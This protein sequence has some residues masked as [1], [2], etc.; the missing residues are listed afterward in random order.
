MVT[1][2]KNCRHLLTG[3][4]KIC[5]HRDFTSR[6]DTFCHF[7]SPDSSQL[8]N[9]GWNP[10]IT[11]NVAHWSSD[12]KWQSSILIIQKCP[13]AALQIIIKYLLILIWLTR[14]ALP[15]EQEVL[16]ESYASSGRDQLNCFG[17][18]CGIMKNLERQ[19]LT[20]TA[21]W[22]S[23]TLS[24]YV[25]STFI[26]THFKSTRLTPNFSWEQSILSH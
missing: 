15:W 1:G 13:A 3:Q 12:P 7:P 23:G 5:V 14:A 24:E 20:Q 10:E 18:G 9:Q 11:F 8:A 25:C 2:V 16:V 19:N 26:G 21:T 22:L 6:L 4:F 17:Y